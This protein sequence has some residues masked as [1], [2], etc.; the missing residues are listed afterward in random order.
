MRVPLK[1]KIYSCVT[2]LCILMCGAMIAGMLFGGERISEEH[3]PAMRELNEEKDA[4]A[5]D[6]EEDSVSGGQ[7]AL[8]ESFIK[9]Q[10]GRFLSDD[11]PLKTPDVSIGADG[12]VS[13][14]GNVSKNAL[15]A[16]LKKMSVNTGLKGSVALLLLPKNFDLDVSFQLS[17]N[18][19]G[20][21]NVKPYSLFVSGKSIP[22]SAFPQK[23]TDIIS[24]AVNNIVSSISSVI[25]FSGFEDGAII[26]QKD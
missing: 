6:E 10:L 2:V 25:R 23:V 17:E 26:F 14:S 7:I 11:F 18:S 24:G 21:L 4:A 22:V 20:S 13:F 3:V 5:L 16:Y 19:D 1:E 9:E 8:T 12:I 15:R